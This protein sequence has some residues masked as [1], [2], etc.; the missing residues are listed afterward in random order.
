MSDHPQLK[1]MKKK[2]RTE[3]KALA[4]SLAPEYR[5]SASDAVF[6]AVTAMPEYREAETIFCFVS[7][8]S[9]VDTH[10]LIRDALTKNK[11]VCVPKCLSLGHMEAYPITSMEKDLEPGTWNI[12]EPRE[13]ILPV[14][15]EELDLV[16]VPCCAWASAK[17]GH[18]KAA[19]TKIRI[20]LIFIM[21]YFWLKVGI[22]F[23]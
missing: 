14:S 19:T 5:R 15:P 20:S 2:I 10:P 16:I 8:P 11:R 6:R 17:T 21:S 12:P 1:E 7:M 22:N 23:S 13:G 18:N 3:A 9:E 4:A